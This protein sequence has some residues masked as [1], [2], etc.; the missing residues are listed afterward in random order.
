M[1][2]V[3]IW[4]MSNEAFCLIQSLYKIATA[5]GTLNNLNGLGAQI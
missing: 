4:V 5:R 1:T 2:L 3:P